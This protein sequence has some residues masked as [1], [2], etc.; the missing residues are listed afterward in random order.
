MLGKSR[1]WNAPGITPHIFSLAPIGKEM[2]QRITDG[3]KTSTEPETRIVVRLDQ[4]DHICNEFESRLC[5]KANPQVEVYL[6]RVAMSERTEML[7]KLVAIE[8]KYAELRDIDFSVYFQ[9]FPE[10]SDVLASLQSELVKDKSDVEVTQVAGRSTDDTSIQSPAILPHLNRYQLINKAGEGGFGTVYEALDRKLERQVAIKLANKGTAA[11]RDLAAILNEAQTNAKL[12][13][14]NIVEVYDVDEDA[15]FIVMHYIDGCNLRRWRG[16]RVVEPVPAAQLVS[17]LANAVQYAHYNGV[18]HRDLKPSNVL[19]DLAGE[20]HIADFGLAKHESAVDTLAKPGEV[21]GTLE[22]MA[23][24]QARGDHDAVERRSDIYSLGVILYELLT[25]RL[26][27]QGEKVMLLSNIIHDA[28]P[29]PRSI[30]PLIPVDLAEICLKCLAK[31]PVDRYVSARELQDDLDRFLEGEVIQGVTMPWQDHV[32]KWISKRYQ[33]V[34]HLWLGLV[35]GMG[36]ISTL[37][38]AS[39]PAPFRQQVVF[40]TEP[41]GSAITAVMLDPATGEP[42]PE[43]IYTLRGRTPLQAKLPPGDYFVVA[44]LNPGA[45]NGDV[46]FM[47]TFRH[48]PDAEEG[49][50]FARKHNFWKMDRSKRILLPKIIIP[51][52]DPTDGMVYI[53][54][55]LIEAPRLFSWESAAELPMVSVSSFYADRNEVSLEDAVRLGSTSVQVSAFPP[56]VSARYDAAVAFAEHVGKRIPFAAELAALEAAA[57]GGGAEILG[58]RSQLWE[59]TAT[60]PAGAKTSK[61]GRGILGDLESKTRIIR[62]GPWPD[63][64]R[65]KHPSKVQIE[66]RSDMETGFRTVRSAKPHLTADDFTTFRKKVP[67]PTE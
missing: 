29:H 9:R 56:F 8:C 20:P 4:L 40:E 37:A 27:F 13:H 64:A 52:A 61:G 7:R 55:S 10:S 60:R 65:S 44:V 45:V 54:E 15:C 30:N 24:E 11:T 12:D 50:A 5:Q 42:D 23:P 51:A 62:N 38:W 19:M 17:K 58:V 32:T 46:R 16:D 26:P 36:V 33:R 2:L 57:D 41:R 53:E 35:A 47:E 63:D 22:Y 43:K 66:H 1:L 28:P 59:W 14:P 49:A 34:R 21:M 25:G 39:M 67:T 6:D 3:K 18:I 48:V 31:S